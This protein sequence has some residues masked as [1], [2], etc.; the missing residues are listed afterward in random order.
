MSF[1]WSLIIDCPNLWFASHLYC[2]KMA[3]FKQRIYLKC[4]K[5]FLWKRERKGLLLYILLRLFCIFK[6][7]YNC[8]TLMVLLLT[9]NSF[10]SNTSC[11]ILLCPF[12][13]LNI[14]IKLFVLFLPWGPLPE[15]PRPRNRFIHQVN[16]FSLLNIDV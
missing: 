15:A 7:L 9:V 8:S 5:L 3:C 4:V 11:Y 14:L 10:F 6:I 2:E 12:H 13:T 16:F 1:F